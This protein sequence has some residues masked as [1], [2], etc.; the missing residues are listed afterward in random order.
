MSGATAKAQNLCLNALVGH[1]Q[2]GPLLV[3]KAK[4]AKP[5]QARRAVLAPDQRTWAFNYVKN[6]VWKILGEKARSRLVEISEGGSSWGQG[7]E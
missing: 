1:P 2:C 3:Q 4:L 5:G 7:S 6:T